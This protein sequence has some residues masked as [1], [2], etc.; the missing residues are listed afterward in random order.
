MYGRTEMVAEQTGK[1]R[2][3]RITPTYSEIN[4]QFAFRNLIHLDPG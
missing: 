3:M 4:S 2:N 1:G